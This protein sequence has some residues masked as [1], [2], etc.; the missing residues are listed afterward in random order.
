MGFTLNE[1]A[2]ATAMRDLTLSILGDT[3]RYTHGQVKE[4]REIFKDHVNTSNV[5]EKYH[6]SEVFSDLE[7]ELLTK[8]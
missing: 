6:L 3:D 2:E 8:Y 1:I 4:L 7:K 5:L